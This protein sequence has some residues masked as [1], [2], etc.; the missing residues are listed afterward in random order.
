M[1]QSVSSE[2]IVYRC[3]TLTGSLDLTH[4]KGM[5]KPCT[6]LISDRN[7]EKRISENYDKIQENIFIER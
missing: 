3:K 1:L 6:R 4:A 7:T 5:N 2:F